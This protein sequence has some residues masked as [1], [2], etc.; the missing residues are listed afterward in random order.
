MIL[1]DLLC[2]KQVEH[3]QCTDVQVWVYTCRLRLA[4]R[5]VTFIEDSQVIYSE[6]Y[7]V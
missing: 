5:L 6:C 7:D 2:D 3:C 4:V 1:K